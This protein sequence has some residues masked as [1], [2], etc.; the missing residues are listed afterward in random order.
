MYFILRCRP[1]LQ[2]A[3]DVRET[4]VQLGFLNWLALNGTGELDLTAN[5]F[6]GTLLERLRSIGHEFDNVASALREQHGSGAGGGRTG[7]GVDGGRGSSHA[8]E[9]V[10]ANLIGHPFDGI[11][12]GEHARGVASA[13]HW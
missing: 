9:A 2:R 6:P 7:G 1:D 8:S 10:G 13:L 12:N 3:F 4:S 11:G 5:V